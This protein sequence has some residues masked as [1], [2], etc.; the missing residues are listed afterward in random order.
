M[1]KALKSSKSNWTVDDIAAG[2]WNR[3]YKFDEN[4]PLMFKVI[5]NSVFV[6]NIQNELKK[7]SK[8]N[9]L[10]ETHLSFL[11]SL[12]E[13]KIWVKTEGHVVP[14]TLLDIYH[15]FA[16]NLRD[17]SFDDQLYNYSLISFMGALGP[18]KEIPLIECLNDRMI[19][20]FLFNSSVKSKIP[21]RKLRVRTSGKI[22][23]SH[24][25]NFESRDNIQI[26]QITDTGILFSSTDGFAIDSFAKSNVLKFHVNTSHL[27]N[28]TESDFKSSKKM[29]DDFFYSDDELRYF[30]V[31]EEKVKRSLSFKSEQT[32]EFFLFVRYHD[33]LESDVPNVFRE[34][35]EKANT[36]F[37]HFTKAA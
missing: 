25:E 11:D 28:F 33:M 27:K 4:T 20:K 16:K 32:N 12:A 6:Q 37:Q 13:V 7:C 9:G 31:E 19:E 30:F 14:M 5:D 26:K 10:Y 3:L 22:L 24:G 15:S 34:F 17:E 18:F 21:T 8:F 29:T 1:G 35:T 36:Y 2:N 23:V